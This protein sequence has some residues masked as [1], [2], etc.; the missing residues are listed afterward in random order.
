MV[1]K[2]ILLALIA[3]FRFSRYTFSY[4]EEVLKKVFGDSAWIE[5]IMLQPQEAIFAKFS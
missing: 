1:Y 2:V 3:L 4:D 5:G